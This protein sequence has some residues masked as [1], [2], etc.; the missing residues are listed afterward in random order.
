MSK[1]WNI[2]V[3]AEMRAGEACAP[4]TLGLEELSSTTLGASM[5]Q[6]DP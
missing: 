1:S 2:W 4:S 5:S 6:V 3:A